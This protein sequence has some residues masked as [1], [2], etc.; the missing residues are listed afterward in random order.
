LVFYLSALQGYEALEDTTQAAAVQLKIDSARR[1]ISANNE[2]LADAVAYVSLAGDC[3]EARDYAQAK[4]YYLLA[5][6]TYAEL[7]EDAKVEEMTYKIEAVDLASYV[8]ATA[9][10]FSLEPP[11]NETE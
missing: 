8:G 11:A 2:K 3:Y 1:K 10:I 7:K 6:N 5:K 9:D 4:K